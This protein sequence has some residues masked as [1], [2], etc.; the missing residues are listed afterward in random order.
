MSTNW[1]GDD[2]ATISDLQRSMA[3]ASLAGLDFSGV[4]RILDIGCGDGF[5]TRSIARR[6]PGAFVAGVDPSPLMIA[7]AHRE[8]RTEIG[9]PRYVIGDVLRLPFGEHFDAVVS[10]NALHWVHD[11]RRALQQIATV[12]HTDGWALV[13]MVCQSPRRSIEDVAQALTAQPRWKARFTGFTAPYFHVKPDSFAGQAR[14]SGL[15]LTDC[16]VA[17]REWHFG[18][19]D[20]FAHWCAVGLGAWTD[21]LDPADR[22][23]FID[24]VVAGYESVVGAAGLVK[25]TQLRATLTPAVD[26]EH[27]SRSG[28]T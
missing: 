7:T 25:F 2:Y 8:S 13:Q 28:T 11:Q 20:D 5:I 3:E 18:S 12:L 16:T 15:Q 10:F 19:R 24:E 17:E 21:R 9:G 6:A 4:Q 1:S 27:S 26:R 14:A 23:R 22:P